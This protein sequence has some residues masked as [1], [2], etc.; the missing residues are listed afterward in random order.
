M[1]L[2]AK[3]VVLLFM[4]VVVKDV[5]SALRGKNRDYSGGTNFKKKNHGQPDIENDDE[6]QETNHLS[7]KQ[8][9]VKSDKL[10]V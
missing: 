3:A 2:Y 5:H 1:A 6:D 10:K 7:N 8:T 4:L 9:H